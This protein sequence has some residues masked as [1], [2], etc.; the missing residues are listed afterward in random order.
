MITNSKMTLEQILD[1]LKEK[2]LNWYEIYDFEQSIKTLIDSAFD[3]GLMSY[4]D[5]D[6]Y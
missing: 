6:D 3:E 4:S 2:N 1:F 5:E